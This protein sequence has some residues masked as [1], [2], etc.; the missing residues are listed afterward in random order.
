LAK[1]SGLVVAP[2]FHSATVVLGNG[3]AT[4]ALEGLRGRL[5]FGSQHL[6]QHE[7]NGDGRSRKSKEDIWSHKL[8]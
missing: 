7:N 3:S 1:E 4:C 2:R 5:T 6:E 8:C